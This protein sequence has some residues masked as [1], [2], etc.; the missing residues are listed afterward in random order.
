MKSKILG[1][2]CFASLA[3]IGTAQAV[4]TEL[5][6]G[7]D[8]FR[9]GG[10]LLNKHYSHGGVIHPDVTSHGSLDFR[11][12][13]V[14]IHLDGYIVLD[15]A[16]GPRDTVINDFEMTEVTGRLDYLIEIENYVQILP[17]VEATVY[18]YNQG[19]TKFNWIGTDVWYM[20]PWEG[21]EVGGSA[22]YNVADNTEP[23]IR[24][25]NHW[26]GSIGSR[27]FYQD[28]PID[29]AFWQV[30]NMASRSYHEITSGADKQGLTTLD[31]GGKLT[32]P[33]PWHETW[34]FL[35]AE[36]HFYINSEDREALE[37][38]GGDKNELVIGIGFE[39]RAE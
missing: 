2:A 3:A 38:S 29:L 15:G 36:G 25:D 16:P 12:Y 31:L 24:H 18:P 1:L 19:A 33:L 10:E 7:P 17:F 20:L 4:E 39:Y 6:V 21:I 8:E 27:Q 9:V 28:A 13:D 14:G 5:Q 34:A 32:M 11:W 30:V 35:K 26:L 22:Q 23:E 37:A